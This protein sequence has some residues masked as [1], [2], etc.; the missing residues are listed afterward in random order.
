MLIEQGFSGRWRAGADRDDDVEFDRPGPSAES[1]DGMR[2]VP[3]RR[4]D[5]GVAG[6]EMLLSDSAHVHVEDYGVMVWQ[7]RRR[8]K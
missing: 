4:V 7:S 3:G 8:I 2:G 1:I 5:G 6:S